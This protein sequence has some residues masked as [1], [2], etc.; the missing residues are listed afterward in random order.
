MRNLL[1]IFSLIFLF[2]SAFGQTEGK[3]P[4]CF[5]TGT[6]PLGVVEVTHTKCAGR[7]CSECKW[8]GKIAQN[9][10][11][12]CK[13]C[14]GTG[15]L[16]EFNKT[17]K[18]KDKIMKALPTNC[19]IKDE[20]GNL[21][22]GK[23][24][25]YYLTD[26][27]K[28]LDE[29][30]NFLGAASKDLDYHNNV[31]FA[32]NI[33]DSWPSG[34]TIAFANLYT[35]NSYT[36]VYGIMK[37]SGDILTIETKD[38]DC[39]CVA[40]GII[41]EKVRAKSENKDI[42]NK[43]TYDQTSKVISNSQNSSSQANT[44]NQQDENNLFKDLNKQLSKNEEVSN[45]LARTYRESQKN[46]ASSSNKSNNQTS[47]NQDEV[48]EQKQQ[49]QQKNGEQQVYVEVDE[50]PEFPGGEFELRTY[51]AKAI[52]YPTVAKGNG[53]QGKVFVTFVI[54]QDGS[55]SNAKIARGVDVS[56]DAEALRIVSTLPKWKP[57]RQRGVPVRVSYTT[58]ISFK[59]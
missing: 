2:D 52:V 38:P 13:A 31:I 29:N 1:L 40:F 59:L 26:S 44:T 58:P 41:A 5:G 34:N 22:V 6:Q 25:Q 39:V 50:M 15:R 36:Q 46:S 56:L 27:R 20:R 42:P 24:S 21:V 54:N 53:I 23:S 17:V 18:A 7:G 48:N 33:Y 11:V 47:S 10:T 3:C 19:I 4:V 57:G 30:K 55:V 28:L 45:E 43:K 14:N 37:G 12:R 16:S 35:E 51:L 9:V 32:K 8:T 49:V